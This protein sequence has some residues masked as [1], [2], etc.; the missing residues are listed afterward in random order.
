MAVNRRNECAEIT[1]GMPPFQRKLKRVIDISCS[2]AGLVLLSP[3]Y[4]AI[5]IALKVQGDGPVFYKQERIGMGGRPFF[6][7][8]FRT[9]RPDAEAN[10]PALAKANDERLTKTGKFLR[11]HHLDELPQL[12]NIFVGDMS[13]VGP[14]PE[15]QYFIDK[16]IKEDPRY[17]CLFRVRPGVT[18]EATLYNGYTSTM[19]KM[20]ERL[21]M[22]LHYLETGSLRKDFSIIFKTIGYII[23]GK[24]N[25]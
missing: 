2:A 14:R 9:M 7:Y 13:F 21:S 24:K 17:R 1:E 19:E 6:I 16:I 15:R 10:G 23:I 3:L 4:A 22:D 12:W 18:S 11:D 8:K 5:S 25:S 20:L